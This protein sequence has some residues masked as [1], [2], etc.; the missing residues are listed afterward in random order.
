MTLQDS[1]TALRRD[2]A[3]AMPRHEEEV[4]DYGAFGFLRGIHERAVSLELR[5][6]N[7]NVLAIGYSWIERMELDLS[8]GITLLVGGKQI[9]ITGRDL[10]REVK[11]HVRLFSAMAQH[12]VPWIQEADESQRFLALAGVP[13]I[14]ELKW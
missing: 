5:K 6:K 3:A 2:S 8:M 12:R 4:Q 13:V 1:L 11:P 14:D 10:D 7:G 9:R